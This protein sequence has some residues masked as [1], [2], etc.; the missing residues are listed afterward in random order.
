MSAPVALEFE[1]HIP[2]GVPRPPVLVLRHGRGADRHDLFGL[3]GRFPDDWAVV[4]PQ[5]PFEATPWGYGPGWAWYRFLG[6][7]SPEPESFTASLRHLAAFLA[8]PALEIPDGAGPIVLGGFSQGGTLALAYALASN[9]GKLGPDAIRVPLAVNLSGFLAD[10]PMVEATPETVAGTRVF[11]G[12]GESDP[13]IGH[14]WAVEGRATLRE[15]GADLEEHDYP[16]GHWI[17]GEEVEDLVR[18][19]QSSLSGPAA[20]GG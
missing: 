10:H 12:H 18:W 13:A 16:I 14:A 15:A 4:A 8:S 2:Q 19:V 7:R 17:V 3:R 6:G 11:W 9:A 1:R 20:E 5:A